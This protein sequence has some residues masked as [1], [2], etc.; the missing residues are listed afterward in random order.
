MD[1]VLPSGRVVKNIPEGTPKDEIRRKLIASGVATDA[2]FERPMGDI[3]MAEA[4][5]RESRKKAVESR[6]SEGFLSGLM[7]LFSGTARTGRD[8]E[9]TPTAMDI[10]AFS[11]ESPQTLATIAPL[12]AMTN[13][14]M[15]MA[16]IIKAQIPSIQ[17]QENIDERG[18][19]YPVLTNEAGQTFMLDKPGIDMMNLGQFLGQ[20]AAFTPAGRATSVPGAIA[21][22]VATEAAIQTGQE[23]AGGEFDVGDVALAGG[24]GGAGKVLEQGLG[25]AYRYVT[26]DPMGTG[27]TRD[28][29]EAGQQFNVPVKT[30]DI[31]PPTTPFGRLSQYTG[32]TVPFVGTGGERVA[33]QEARENAVQMYIDTY[34]GGSY[35]NIIEEIGKRHESLKEPARQVYRQYV[36]K[37]DEA[38]AVPMTNTQQAIDKALEFFTDPGNEIGESTS[39]LLQRIQSRTSGEQTFSN[40][41]NNVQFFTNLV[42]SID[43]EV[44]SQ[45]PSNQKRLFDNIL[46]AMREDRDLFAR[47]NLD[48]NQYRQLKNADAVWGDISSDLQNRRLKGVLDNGDVTPELARNML[49]SSRQS[50]LN[51]LFKSLTPEGRANARSVIIQDIFE[52]LDKR[53]TGLT[54][55]AFMAEIK[56]RNKTIDTFFRGDE[57]K[58]LNGLMRLLEHTRRAQQINATFASPT[59]ERLMGA[60]ALASGF[61]NPLIPASYGSIGLAAKVY[62]SPRVRNIMARLSSIP[63]GSTQFEKAARELQS[64]LQSSAQALK[65]QP[66]DVEELS[67]SVRESV[68]GGPLE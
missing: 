48:A 24:L 49:M 17:V 45:M 55:D 50:E 2:D 29:I 41:K 65:E 40:V 33:Q 12:M 38:G 16:R 25:T 26:G 60:G 3:Q 27:V 68:G 58:Q 11:G 59:G 10:G 44:R 52:A 57:R 36:P 8:I 23:M 39:N 7:D 51:T 35:E 5:Q 1:L 22:E 21:K 46:K 43:P 66:E 14:P 67:K 53:Q 64:A 62:E 15:E 31:A 6:D 20:A 13:D 37:L 63:P 18:N 42:E 28:V 9:R 61:V 30:T 56:K 47:A 32:E 54:P 4:L 19:V 34:K